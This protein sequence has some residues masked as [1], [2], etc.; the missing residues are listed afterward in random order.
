M[1]LVQL[2]DDEMSVVLDACKP[3]APKDRDP[4]LRTLA[5]ELERHREVGPGKIHRIVRH[6]QRRYYD[7]PN[8]SGSDG[9]KYA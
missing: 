1:P 7:P 3:L 8:L 4:F 9:G 6:M 5:D 2:S